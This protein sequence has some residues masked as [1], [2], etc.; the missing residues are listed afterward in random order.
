MAQTH[1]VQRGETIIQIAQKY[2]FRAWEPIW[3]HEKNAALR[4]KRPN[5]HVLADGD[6]LHIPDKTLQDHQCET[7]KRHVFKVR[8]LTQKIRQV[9]LD[10]KDQPLS[11]KRF[12][13]S[14]GGK[15][16]KGTTGGDGV[17]ESDI[18]IT[19]RSAEL[20]V[21]LIDGD[22]KSA[23][24]WTL[25]V[26]ELEPVDKIYGIKGHLLNLGYDCG[27]VNDQLDQKTKEAIT[28]FQGDHNLPRT[29]ANDA[30]TQGKL[31]EIFGYPV[32]A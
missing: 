29:G 17:V 2:K 25:Q 20:K 24:T 11:G 32:E 26:G 4:A 1:M 9:L 19:V 30:A 31:R 15:T 3:N 8:S 13:L 6:E 12:E 5:A 16:L 21:W 28:A 10:E 18:P 27:P 14:A 22:D 23:V 7:N